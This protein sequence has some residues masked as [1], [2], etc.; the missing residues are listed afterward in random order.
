MNYIHMRTNQNDKGLDMI[1]PTKQ[2]RNAY[3]SIFQF[4]PQMQFSRETSSRILKPLVHMHLPGHAL[5]VQE[6][7]CSVG[8]KHLE[9]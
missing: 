1:Y 7:V 5:V 4:S 2:K 3:S 9:P 6:S 8:P